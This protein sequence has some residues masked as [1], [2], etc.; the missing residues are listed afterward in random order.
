ML[1]I[2]KPSRDLASMITFLATVSRVIEWADRFPEFV[3]EQARWIFFRDKI[4]NSTGDYVSMKI[5]A[6]ELSTARGSLAW[7]DGEIEDGHE[8]PN[9]RKTPQPFSRISMQ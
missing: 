6:L 3:P 2:R 5:L 8:W 7:L 4:G 9:D 1:K